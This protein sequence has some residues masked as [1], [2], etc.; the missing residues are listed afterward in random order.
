[1]N[2]SFLGFAMCKFSVDNDKKTNAFSL[3]YGGVEFALALAR[4]ERVGLCLQIFH[5]M[6]RASEDS[7]THDITSKFAYLNN[8]PK[9]VMYAYL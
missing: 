5:A 3:A 7:I 6:T 2:P 1:M 4:D 9:R 8:P